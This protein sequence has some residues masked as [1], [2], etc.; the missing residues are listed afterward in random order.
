VPLSEPSL[1]S[2]R[3]FVVQF[4]AQPAG[5]A[6]ASDGRVE[7]VVSGQ[8]LR[9]HALAEWLAFMTRVLTEV[10]AQAGAP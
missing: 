9:F 5:A 2:N 3:G 6:S 1:P 10:E 8:A 7:H 4:R